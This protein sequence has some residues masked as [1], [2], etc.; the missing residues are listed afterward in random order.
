MSRALYRAL[1]KEKKPSRAGAVGAFFAEGRPSAKKWFFFNFF[2]KK[3]LPRASSLALGKEIFRIFPKKN[4]CRG[5]LQGPAAKVFFKKKNCLPRAG[6]QQR[7][8]VFFEFFLKT[9]AE[10]L[11]PG[12][13]QRNFQ[14]FSQKNLCRGLLLGPSAKDPSLPR[15][16]VIALGKETEI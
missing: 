3:P 2:F 10:G 6:P 15:A 1:G 8:C 7:N 13:R 4:L 5:L 14:D 9:F 12:P 11:L 16:L